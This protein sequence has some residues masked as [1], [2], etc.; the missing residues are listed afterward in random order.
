MNMISKMNLSMKF[1]INQEKYRCGTPTCHQEELG[2]DFMVIL[3][4][5]IMAR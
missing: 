5:E 2:D 1:I 3:L 4:R